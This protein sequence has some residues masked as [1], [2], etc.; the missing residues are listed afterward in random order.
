MKS[1]GLISILLILIINASCSSV[2]DEARALMKRIEK[3]DK[4]QDVG[5]YIIK[6]GKEKSIIECYAKKKWDGF[7]RKKK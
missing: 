1:L 4:I 3:E 5:I 2:D 7:N 6:N